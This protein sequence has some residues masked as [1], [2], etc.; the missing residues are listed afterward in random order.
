MWGCFTVSNVGLLPRRNYYY[1]MPQATSWTCPSCGRHVP[2][3]VAKCRCGMTMPDDPFTNE[4]GPGANKTATMVGGAVLILALL[5]TGYWTIFRTET[6]TLQ[7]RPAPGSQDPGLDIPAPAAGTPEASTTADPAPAPRPSA[8]G[9]PSAEA[10]AWNSVAG[11]SP[12]PG[13]SDDAT[14]RAT[15]ATVMV[16]AGTRR[17]SGFFVAADTVLT[18]AHVVGD[19]TTVNVR[20]PEGLLAEA[21][22]YARAATYD[23]AALKLVAPSASQAVLRLGTSAA[24]RPGQEVIVIGAS[25]GS[26]PH[27]VSRG[28]IT[29]IRQRDGVRVVQTDAAAEAGNSGGPML[30]EL[31]EVIAILTGGFEDRARAG[32]GVSV[33]YARELLGGR[34]KDPGT[35]GMTDLKAAATP[36]DRQLMQSIA[37]AAEGAN[38]LDGVWQRFRATCYK[39]RIDGAFDREWF[40]AMTPGA[41]PADAAAACRN[42]FAAMTQ[43]MNRIRDYLRTA[44]QEARR[45]NVADSIIRNELRARQLTFDWER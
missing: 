42:D 32:F 40:A 31:G 25:P 39:G 21:T 36:P 16:E 8:R 24:V 14:S 20:L 10:L 5:G 38:N 2:R 19:M 4:D 27:T 45:A 1:P 26:V 6:R 11:T 29:E 33:D 35:G 37:S 3:K 30:N 18:N 43:E 23:I 41:I 17:G 15:A 13:A 34:L 22:V 44:L 12:T 28:V 9:G 7:I